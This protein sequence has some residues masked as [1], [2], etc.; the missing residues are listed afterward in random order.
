MSDEVI[1]FWRL[2]TAAEEQLQW[3]LEPETMEDTARALACRH[4]GSALA[5]RLM[6]RAASVRAVGT[7][8]P[9]H[10]ARTASAAAS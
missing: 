4:P 8:M 5:E 2:L 7:R 1:P 6:A 10:G 3:G 9:S